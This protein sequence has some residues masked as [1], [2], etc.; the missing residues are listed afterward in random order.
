MGQLQQEPALSRLEVRWNGG[1][2][3]ASI[4]VSLLGAFTSTQMMCQARTSRYF[5]GV[6]V[7]TI[8]G[9]LTFGFCSI[10]C[11][12]FIAMLA[13]ELPLP[14]GLNAPLTVLSAALA[15]I[16]TFLALAADPMRDRYL[17]L[18]KKGK[19]MAL[20]RERRKE[21]AR[22]DLNDSS[23]ALL[24]ARVSGEGE[25]AQVIAQEHSNGSADRSPASRDS[26]ASVTLGRLEDHFTSGGPATSTAIGSSGPPQRH[27]LPSEAGRKAFSAQNESS[28]GE[29]SP[30]DTESYQR[31]SQRSSQWSS[32][33]E[34]RSRRSST[35][36]HSDSSSLGLPG[37]MS[38]RFSKSTTTTTANVILGIGELLYHGATLTNFCKGFIWSLAITTMHYVGLLAL[39]IPR[40]HVTLQ[41]FLVLLS[42]LCAWLVCTLGCILMPQIEVN[43]SQQLIF[44]VVAAAGVAA[45]HFTGM[46]ATTFWSQASPTA[47]RGYPP[48]LAVAVTSIAI[49]TCLLA[50]GLLAHSATVARNK[51]AEI[52]HTRRKL[53]AAIAQKENAEAAA[54]VRSEF[55]ASASHE[56]RTPLHQLQGYSDLLSRME[57]SE[58]ARLLLL[59][60]Q[61]ATRSLSMITANVLDWSRLEKGEAV[62]R[63]T[64][65]DLRKVCESI[66]AI[67]PNKEEDIGTELMIVVAPQV[68]SS[69]FLDETYL[70]RILMNLL[71]NALKFTQS[72]YVLLLVEITDMDLAIT[73]RDSGF[74]IPESFLPHLFEPFKQAQTRGAER[75]TG[76]GLA[77][78]R[79]LLQKME[80]TIAVESKS[81]QAENVGAENCGSIFTV[82]I[83]ID[84][85]GDV[86]DGLNSLATN[87]RIALLLDCN[88]RFAEGLQ[89]AWGA[90]DFELIRADPDDEISDSFG[91]VWTDLMFLTKNPKLLGR[92]LALRHQ[93]VILSYDSQTLLDESLGSVP[94]PHVIPVKRPFVWH[95]MVESIVSAARTGRSSV[96]R[97]VRFAPVVDVVDDNQNSRPT[98][99]TKTLRGATVLLVE[100]NKINQKLGV[101]MLNTL[102]YSVIVADDGQEAIDKLVE[103]DNDIDIILMDQSMPRMDGITATKRIREM[104]REALMGPLTRTRRPIIMVTAV[105][106]P[107]AQALCM[108][109]GTDAFLPKPLAMSK[110]EHTLKK[111]LG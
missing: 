15:V 64:S 83:P 2:I 85:S 99:E 27:Q 37:F 111:F 110:L 106:G 48:D 21:A 103:H 41:P 95:R 76:L 33:E 10:W 4:A 6:L 90:F 96:D 52:V 66:L 68:P 86:P 39:E 24:G 97:S 65:L 107:D 31:S 17:R 47:E 45:M 94:P 81:H 108:S 30:R 42:A 77:I 13:C 92:I 20:R 50:N 100:D 51:L 32:E 80:G 5:S 71:T 105:V 26:G 79:Q 53:W 70:Q 19:A 56:I 7:W 9:S 49:L 11:L 1:L 87:R 109:A 44:S 73:V 63:P 55:I 25:E 89:L 61:Q 88:P 22:Q 57:L 72:G 93:L 101:K 46:W 59:A 102:G 78:I 91:Y 16:F 67:L 54:A 18:V 35:T 12:H 23:D 74:G 43:L 84:P 69:L 40:G 82:T 75:G 34:E 60:I 38:F 3:A 36:N 104:E 14:I 29:G 98:H 8:L 62:C 58:D 28:L